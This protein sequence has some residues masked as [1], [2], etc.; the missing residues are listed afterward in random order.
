M[1]IIDCHTH[2][3]PEPL[4]ERAI[5]ALEKEAG[6]KAHL[7]GT[8]SSLLRSMDEAGIE[9]SIVCSIATKPEQ[10]E[11]I[12]KWSKQIASERIIPFPSIHPAD[13]RAGDLVPLLHKEG[14]KGIKLHPYYQNCDLND[15]RLFPVYE[16]LAAH[17]MIITAHTG[18]DIAFQPFRKADA[19][20]VAEVIDRFPGLTFLTTHLGGWND[21]AEVRRHLVG[22]PVY[23]E[24]SFTNGYLD[25]EELIEICTIHGKEYILFGTDSPWTDQRQ[26]VERFKALDL[27]D[28]FKE[29]VLYKNA[30]SLL[31]LS[32]R[33]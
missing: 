29:H 5:P 9:R 12:L 31:G 26:M 18:F 24:I 33:R 32:Q 22:K 17:D 23:M 28:D 7:D 16:Q 1:P 21:W 11:P 10:F 3:F 13:P 4:A 30:A 2:A 19:R 6:I 20:K 8:L 25:D 15:E 27:D 14:F